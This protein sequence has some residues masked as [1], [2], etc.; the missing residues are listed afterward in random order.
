[1]EQQPGALGS[2]ADDDSEELE[3]IT[4]DM[5][6]CCILDGDVNASCGLSGCTAVPRNV[7]RVVIIDLLR[8]ASSSKQ[9]K[10]WR[11]AKHGAAILC[12]VLESAQF[13]DTNIKD[14]W[15]VQEGL[16]PCCGFHPGAMDGNAAEFHQCTGKTVIRVK[17]SVMCKHNMQARCTW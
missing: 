16:T 5:V 1:M 14:A 8:N 9:H 13:T 6:S 7:D 10:R 17:H 11:L 3:A 12:F 4:Q 15:V 2:T